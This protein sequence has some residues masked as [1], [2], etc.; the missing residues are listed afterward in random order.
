MSGGMPMPGGWTMSMAW[1]KMPSQ[2][3]LSMTSAFIGMWIVMM[4]AM[5]LPSLMTSLVKCKSAKRAVLA[6]TGYFVVWTLFGFIAYAGG[7]LIAQLAMQ[8]SKFAQ[9][10]PAATAIVVALC[11]IFQLTSWKARRL[12]SCCNPEAFSGYSGWYHGV[13]LGVNCAICCFGFMLSLLVIDIMDLRAMALI[14]VAIT[15]ERISP[16]RRRIAIISGIAL[17]AAGVALYAFRI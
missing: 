9:F 14:A 16:Y 3:W 4:V 6:F 10:V 13:K 2:T 5:M 11:G 7:L 1:M 12:A 15:I 17:I 8:S